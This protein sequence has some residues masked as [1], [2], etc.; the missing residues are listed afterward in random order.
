MRTKVF[1]REDAKAIEVAITDKLKPDIDKYL[2]EKWQKIINLLADFFNVPAALIMR[3]TQHDMEVFL[4]SQND[5]N[6]YPKNGKDHLMHGLYCE[7]VIGRDNALLIKNALESEVWKSNPDVSLNMIAYYG[8][9][10]KWN[11]GTFFGTICTLDDKENDYDTKY[12]ELLLTFKDIIEYDLFLIEEKQRLELESGRDYLTKIPNRRTFEN[13]AF[14]NFKLYLSQK[15]KF[16]VLLIDINGF[17]KINDEYGH[18]S[19][20]R[21]LIRF[22]ESINKIVKE[23][24]LFARYGGD[25]FIF[26]LIESDER[27]LTDF[28]KEINK[29]I[30]NDKMLKKHNLSISWGF[31]FVDD[32]VKQISDLV[33][34]ADKNLYQMKNRI[35]SS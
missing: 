28:I 34:I 25:E 24:D 5:D 7:T 33:D 12:R 10:L 20:D 29:A 3:I 18:V 32:R 26:L 23:S 21:I 16:C 17:K 6:P 9:P 13:F 27:F 2:Q 1:L 31:A 19:G 30:A 14:E 11:D 4:K 8:L 22:A 35:K 15:L